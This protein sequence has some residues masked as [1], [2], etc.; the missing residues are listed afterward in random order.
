MIDI[1]NGNLR[2]RWRKL[3]ISVQFFRII[4]GKITNNNID[5]YQYTDESF[6]RRR[7]SSLAVQKLLTF[8]Q[9]KNIRTLYIEFAKTVNAMTLNA[10]VK[11]TTLWTTGPSASDFSISWP[12]PCNR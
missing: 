9:Q 7:I 10:L 12:L 3:I 4:L 5:E 8:F 11:L 2:R 6:G 1:Y